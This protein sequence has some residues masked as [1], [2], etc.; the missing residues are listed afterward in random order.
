MRTTLQLEDDVFIHAKQLAAAQG[1]PLGA[2]VSALMRQGIQRTQPKLKTRNG[3]PVFD[4][5][6]GGR[7]VTL[8]D[9]KRA[10][11]EDDEHYAGRFT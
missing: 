1:K 3:F 10:E 8:E 11:E 2:V 6:P 4:V 7:T 9:V 5:P